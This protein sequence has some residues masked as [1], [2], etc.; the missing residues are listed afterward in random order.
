MD[1]GV[2]SFLGN[3]E[4]DGVEQKIRRRVWNLTGQ[5]ITS[6]CLFF[7]WVQCEGEHGALGRLTWQNRVDGLGGSLK[8]GNTSLGHLK[9]SEK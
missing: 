5:S 1:L 9:G 8:Q 2:K 3:N 4:A 7:K 6:Q